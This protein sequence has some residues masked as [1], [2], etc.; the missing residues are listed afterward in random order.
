MVE[1]QGAETRDQIR[2]RI[3]A[4]FYQTLETMEE[5][6]VVIEEEDGNI[7]V[8]QTWDDSTNT[9]VNFAVCKF[10]EGLVPDDFKPYFADWDQH[11]ASVNDTI[12]T[13]SKVGSDNGVDI[14]KIL[15]KAPWPIWQRLMF[16]TSYL[17]LDQEDGSHLL[18]MCSDSNEQ[19]TN[20]P[21]IYTEHDKGNY[22]LATVYCIGT[23]V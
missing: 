7:Q 20:N 2:Q 22:V 10:R 3:K 19:Y 4:K 14:M 16:T 12:D 9:M 15:I 5:H 21:E 18:L 11:G 23:L 17:E 1:A 13:A 6:P 8:R